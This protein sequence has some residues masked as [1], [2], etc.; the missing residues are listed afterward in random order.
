MLV[1]FRTVYATSRVPRR[2][3][4]SSKWRPGSSRWSV[5]PERYKSFPWNVRM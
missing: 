1:R 2:W 3:V 5:H 4:G